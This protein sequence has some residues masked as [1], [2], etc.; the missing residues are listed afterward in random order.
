MNDPNKPPGSP[1]DF[2]MEAPEVREA[3]SLKNQ[4]LQEAE[5]EFQIEQNR[6][7]A[8]RKEAD[9]QRREFEAQSKKNAAPAKLMHLLVAKKMSPTFKPSFKVVGMYSNREIM[10]EHLIPAMM[11]YEE[12]GQ[13][14]G[15]V[16]FDLTIKVDQPAIEP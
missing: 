14:V 7:A 2:K 16:D 10:A 4:S 1:E 8:E 5:R 6:I 9:R 3:R 15:V 13:S 11:A 12:A